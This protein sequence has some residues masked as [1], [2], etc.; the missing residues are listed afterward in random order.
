MSRV[1]QSGETHASVEAADGARDLDLAVVICTRNRPAHLRQ[2]LDA[3]LDN[4]R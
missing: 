2:A 4:R 1:I 3:V